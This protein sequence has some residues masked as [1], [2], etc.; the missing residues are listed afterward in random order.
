MVLDTK[1]YNNRSYRMGKNQTLIS[2]KRIRRLKVQGYCNFSDGEISQ[3]S[4]GNKFAFI[5]CSSLLLLGVVT[6]NIPIL[7]VMMLIALFG[8]ILPYHPFDYIYN[9]ALARRLDKPQLPPRSKQ[10]KF[11]C[12]IAT[13]MIGITIYLFYAGY[14]TAGYI[15]GGSL[16]LVAF[17]VSTTDICIPSIIFNFLFKVEI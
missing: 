1:P 7:L 15:T 13:L 11:A 9:Y 4:F 16:F 3:F 12:T 14:S 5:I 8:I 17:L 10:L 2:S 6:S